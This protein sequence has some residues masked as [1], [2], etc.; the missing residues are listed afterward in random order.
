M[1]GKNAARAAPMLALNPLSRFSA[2]RISG[3]RSSTSEGRPGV[4]ILHGGEGF[5]KRLREQLGRNRGADHQVEGVFVLGHQGGVAGDI[6]PRR[7]H[8][9]LRLPQI[10]LGRGPHLKAALDQLVGGLLGREGLLGQLQPLAVGGQIQVVGSH[11]GH[12]ADLHGAPRLL[13]GEILLQGLVLQALHPAEQVEFIGADPE[14]DAVLIDGFGLTGGREVSGIRC[15]L[16][17]AVASILRKQIGALDLVL[18]PRPL[19]VEGRDPQVAVVRP[20]PGRSA[21]AAADR[22]RTPARDD[23]PPSCRHGCRCRP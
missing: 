2:C 14:A 20:G 23:R 7:I 5:G 10:Q 11:L 1:R 19:D 13:G 6:H 12:Q 15:L 3:R 17:A 16:P 8:P 4:E 9:G 21:S 18:G 22:Q